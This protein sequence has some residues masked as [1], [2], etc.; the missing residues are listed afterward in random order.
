MP[1]TE[2][3]YHFTDSRNIP[4]IREH[5]LFSLAALRARLNFDIGVDFFPASSVSSREIDYRK[6]LNNYIRLC[7]DTNHPMVTIAVNENRIQ[8]VSWIRLNFADIVFRN[9]FRDEHV[10]FS[11]KN[12]ASNDAIV[13]N[14]FKT[15]TQSFDTQREVLIRFNIPV[16]R[17][18]FL[19]D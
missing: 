8:N 17:L 3:L 4:S 19:E 11:N 7:A 10:K 2:H 6:N 12:A 1:Y 16:S 9:N 13:N 14:N 18:E 15:F 5:G